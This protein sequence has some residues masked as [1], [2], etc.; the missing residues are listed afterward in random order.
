MEFS[1]KSGPD[2][3]S[4]LNCGSFLSGDLMTAIWF[5]SAQALGCVL[6]DSS[7]HHLQSPFHLGFELLCVER[8]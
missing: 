6:L 2:T 3:F 7:R 5:L 1:E 8:E 4:F